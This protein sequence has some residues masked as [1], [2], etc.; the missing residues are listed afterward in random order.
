M[1]GVKGWKQTRIRGVKATTRQ[2]C[3]VSRPPPHPSPGCQPGPRCT[4]EEHLLYGVRAAAPPPWPQALFVDIPLPPP[5]P[6][7][8]DAPGHRW[9]GPSQSLVLSQIHFFVEALV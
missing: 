2:R 8:P 1:Q 3:G 4:S 9:P 7:L 6:S 5:P